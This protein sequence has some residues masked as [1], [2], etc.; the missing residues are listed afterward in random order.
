MTEK[1]NAKQQRTNH[2][3]YEGAPEGLEKDGATTLQRTR[4]GQESQEKQLICLA[5]ED[6]EADI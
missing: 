4:Q 5:E 2:Q 3:Q 6:S 1:R